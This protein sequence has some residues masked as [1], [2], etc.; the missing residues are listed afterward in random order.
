ML[1]GK[2]VP[3]HPTVPVFMAHW[4]IAASFLTLRGAKPRLE[5]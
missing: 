2:Q 5:G 3:E 1:Q 4:R